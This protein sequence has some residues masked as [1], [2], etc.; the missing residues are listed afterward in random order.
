MPRSVIPGHPPKTA[1]SDGAAVTRRFP[2]VT[3]SVG[4]ARRF[5]I[6]ALP[7]HCLV[8]ADGVVLMLS[9]LATNAVQHASTPFDV[10]LAVA[11]DGMSVRVAVSDGAG[12]YPAPQ[13][14]NAEAPCG[15][16]LHI[17]CTLADT[18]GIE[19][20][21]DQPGKTVWFDGS[22]AAP[23]E[24]LTHEGAA[25]GGRTNV[26]ETSSWTPRRS[27]TG[28]GGAAGAGGAGGAVRA[29]GTASA[30]MAMAPTSWPTP[31]VRAVL[32]GLRDAV[33]ATDAD[34]EIH[35][36]NAAAE[37]LMG[38]PHGSLVGR[39]ALDLVPDSLSAAFDAGFG[40]FIRSRGDELIGRKLST[41][42]R[43]ADG[44][45]VDTELVLSIFDHPHGGT[46]V[47]GIFRA[48]DDRK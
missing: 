30:G 14:P 36:V 26:K 9:E 2:A 19:M 37:E 23:A 18:W 4:Q 5:L 43:C 1:A 6:E 27:T 48:R 12:G 7:P 22:L 41:V 46:V 10:T 11:P 34:G 16:G 35:Y 25:L 17:V 33:V 15:R 28:A 21:R 47:V 42:I 39:S 44:S 32:D 38:W 29:G 20:R 3:A 13:E 31:S 40:H 45:E 24:P 8:G